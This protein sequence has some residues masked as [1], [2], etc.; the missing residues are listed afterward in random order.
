MRVIEIETY[1]RHR[2]WACMQR[3]R[4]IMYTRRQIIRGTRARAICIAAPTEVAYLV[5][6]YQAAAL[7]ALSAWRYRRYRGSFHAQHTSLAH[8]PAADDEAEA[9]FAVC[10]ALTKEALPRYIDISSRAIAFVWLSKRENFGQF[11]AY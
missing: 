10:L 9:C 11:N 3:P 6:R 2:L 5:S 1:F 7:I 8:A 4:C